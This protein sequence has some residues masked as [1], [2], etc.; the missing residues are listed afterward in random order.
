MPHIKVDSSKIRQYAE[1][2]NDVVGKARSIS[3]D[4]SSLCNSLDWDIKAEANINSRCRQA[5][6]QLQKECR[7]VENM[8]D[9]LSTAAQ[10]Y[11][12]TEQKISDGDKDTNDTESTST[13]NA[14][15]DPWY[16]RWG[17][18]MKD[19]LLKKWSLDPVDL[20]TGNLIYQFTDIEIPGTS[21]FAFYRTYNSQ[22]TVNGVLGTEWTHNYE[23]SLQPGEKQVVLHL[24][25]GKEVRF[26]AEGGHF[27]PEFGNQGSLGKT[28]TGYHYDSKDDDFARRQYDFDEEGKCTKI[29]DE[30]GLD[31]VLLYTDGNLHEIKKAGGE[32]LRLS[33]DD[34]D[35]LIEVTDHTGRKV[36]YAYE[37]Q[38]LLRVKLPSG[39]EIGYQYSSRGKLAQ[40]TNELGFVVLKN[41][42]DGQG[43]TVHQQFPDGSEMHYEYDDTNGNIILTDRNGARTIYH[44]DGNYRNDQ[45]TYSDGV[46]KST[47]SANNLLMSRVDKNGARTQFAYDNRNNISRIIN[48]VGD[49]TE[50]TYNEEDQPIAMYINGRRKYLQSY[51]AN[52][53]LISVEDARG[54]RKEISYSMD[55]LPTSFILEDGC[56]VKVAYDAHGNIS[57]INGGSVHNTYRYDDLNRPVETIDGNGHVT[58]FAYDNGNHIVSIEDALGQKTEYV[59]DA[60]GNT[61]QVTYP[62][63]SSLSQEFNSLGQV[64]AV[65][66]QLGRKT[67]YDYDLMWNLSGI[68]YA[69]GSAV[70]YIYDTNNH[71]S[72]E[73]DENDCERSYTYDPEGRLLSITDENGNP[74]SFSYD[75]LGRKTEIIGGEGE[76]FSL[77]YDD[78]D[79]ITKVE[80]ALGNAVLMEYDECGN[81]IRETDRKGASRSYTYNALQ[82]IESITDEAGKITRFYYKPGGFPERIVYPSGAVESYEYDAAGNIVHLKN[83]RGYE[84][85]YVYDALNRVIRKTGSDGAE[86]SFTYDFNHHITSITDAYGKKTEYLYTKTGQ[87]SAVISAEGNRTDYEYDLRDRL[88][89]VIRHGESERI[90]ELKR[91]R[92]GRIVAAIDPLGQEEKFN[93]NAGGQ[94]VEKL[95]KD[96]FL[97]KYEYYS[98][99]N[100]A[101]VTYADGRKAEYE[102]NALRQLIAVKDWLGEHRFELD[103]EG[104]LLKAVYPDGKTVSYTYTAENDRS[105]MIYPDGTEARYVYDDLSRL[106]ELHTKDGVIRYEYDDPDFATKKIMPN[107]IE[108][109]C[110][111]DAAG[112]VKTLSVQKDG[113]DI[114]RFSYEYDRNGNRTSIDRDR[115]GLSEASGHFTFA[116][117]GEGKLLSVSK[118]EKLL[119][120]YTYDAFGNRVRKTETDGAVDYSYNS[121]DQLIREVRSGIDAWTIEYSYDRRG[122]MQTVSENGSEVRKLAFD[123]SNRLIKAVGAAGTTAEYSYDGLGHRICRREIGEQSQK[124]QIYWNDYTRTYFNLLATKSVAGTEEHLQS[125]FYDGPV[126]ALSSDKGNGYYFQDE[127]GSTARVFGDAGQVLETD[128]YDEFGRQLITENQRIQPISYTGHRYDDLTGFYYTHGRE[129]NPKTGA[130]ISTD[131][132]GG[133][134]FNPIGFNSYVYCMMNPTRY[135]DPDGAWV[136]ILIG[137]L[138]GAVVDTSGAIVD[139]ALDGESFTNLKTWAKIGAKTA[140]G[141]VSGSVTAATGSATAGSMAGTTTSTLIEDLA[142]EHKSGEEL[143]Q[144]L[145]FNVGYA[146]ITGFTT[147]KISKAPW[148]KKA[149][150]KVQKALHIDKISK[151]IDKVSKKLDKFEDKI[152]YKDGG[153]RYKQYLRLARQNFKRFRKDGKRIITKP[154]PITVGQG[155]LSG[156]LGNRVKDAKKRIKKGFATAVGL[157]P[158]AGGGSL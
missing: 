134:P 103:P 102:Y 91:D 5:N 26:F 111:Y 154:R 116:Y 63:G 124:D 18:G 144:D 60:A 127:M 71:L 59:Y 118:G 122:N 141:F 135:M 6:S 93:Y 97:T 142:I 92:A 86:K 120:S 56:I 51:D 32:A 10:K 13:V 46:E 130:F 88:I 82:Q 107:G 44:H 1:T 37:N 20:A 21:S 61:T 106:S 4:F 45:V 157:C 25:D 79:H 98:D 69:D 115:M 22:D 125:Y 139:A 34:S 52:G 87:L 114:D 94:L 49:K 145:V 89:R 85:D 66:D 101:S 17:K 14:V 155:V 36:T 72:K 27:I 29:T 55:G 113:A 149:T 104:N 129:Y 12:E 156:I 146:G 105:S 117:D 76:H 28:A 42:F 132:E 39:G 24:D 123:A 3:S 80:D 133:R 77:I 137:G 58:K 119:R 131:I 38:R 40:I 148:F 48:A 41:T 70:K 109:L 143:A 81:L 112:H 108:A 100:M 67:A 47:F 53:N 50:F 62:D 83:R 74:V 138:V 43:R 90:E 15:K 68:R 65:T 75:L 7:S 64:S 147:E 95:D 128:A 73:V 150:K 152:T 2:L 121:L 99:G 23:I 35:R 84:V 30:E 126:A 54:N 110:S 19:R 16:K 33:Y 153:K 96:G 8:R 140:S 57:E 158:A 31:L 136:H 78:E 11:D 151:N 9:F